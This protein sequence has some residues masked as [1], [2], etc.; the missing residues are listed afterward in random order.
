MLAKTEQSKKNDIKKSESNKKEEKKDLNALTPLSFYVRKNSKAKCSKDISDDDD[1]EDE[2]ASSLD[3]NKSNNSDSDDSNNNAEVN[4]TIVSELISLKDIKKRDKLLNYI[5]IRVTHKSA[6]KF[7][8]EKASIQMVFQDSSHSIAA[9]CCQ[10]K[11][12]NLTDFSELILKF[13]LNNTYKIQ[14]LIINSSNYTAKNENK[15]RLSKFQLIIHNKTVVEEID[16]HELAEMKF[17]FH[18]IRQI[19]DV[20]KSKIFYINLLGKIINIDRIRPVTVPNKKVSI[21][22]NIKSEEGDFGENF[23]HN[24]LVLNVKIVDDSNRSITLAL[25]DE[26]V[27]YF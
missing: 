27:I 8:N 23:N 15:N 16:S 12:T 22:K 2:D 21:F 6:V 19:K 3:L 11:N 17:N 25:W 9:K 4:K 20:F 13:K 14:N 7:S 18:Q 24:S 1:D 26:E 10:D 5:K